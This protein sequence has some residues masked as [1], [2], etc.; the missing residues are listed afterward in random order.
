MRPL[1]TGI[2]H[3]YLSVTDFRKSE[4]FYDQLMAALGFR[5]SNMPI[6]GEEHAHYYAPSLQLSIR[7]AKAT[8]RHCP[9]LAGLHH[10][11]FRCDTIDDV[12]TC[13]R[14]LSEFE[15]L[16]AKPKLYPEYGPDYYSFFFTD[17]D[18]IRLEIVNKT[19]ERKRIEDE[20]D[21]RS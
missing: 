7:P 19:S 20:W 2:D 15:N 17:P 3:I 8:T 21:L 11:C 16:Q 12:D 4:I 9:Y 13:F 1:L 18:G 6:A 14:L 5:K 10:L